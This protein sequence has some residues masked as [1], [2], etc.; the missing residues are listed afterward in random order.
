MN[1]KSEVLEEY[2][3][4]FLS[5]LL[6]PGSLLMLL[7]AS[8]TVGF[9]LAVILAAAR[10]ASARSAEY[11]LLNPALKGSYFHETV[12]NFSEQYYELVFSSTSILLFVGVYFVLV[13]SDMDSFSLGIENTQTWSTYNGLLL[14]GFIFASMLLNS[15]VDRLIIPLSHLKKGERPSLRL[16]SMLYMLIVFAYIKFIYQDNNYDMIILYFLTLVI[17]RFVYFDATLE[18]FRE[19]VGN[20]S[21]TLPALA[22]TLASTAVMA[23]AGFRSGYMVTRY[24]VVLNLA[25]G[26]I[27][28][29]IVIFI[30][31]RTGLLENISHRMKTP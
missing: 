11:R 20:L 13:R 15:I 4:Y 19:A 8:L 25:L 26:H 22:L 9:S 31:H 1:S 16:A 21:G 7:A 18:S 3:R 14:L 10:S 29:L 12:R 27:G 17:S 5:R 23:A 28:L 2:L 24:S 30:V 6:P